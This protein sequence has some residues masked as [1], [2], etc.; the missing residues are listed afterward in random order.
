MTNK[1]KESG[2]QDPKNEH[3]TNTPPK[4]PGTEEPNNSKETGHGN[5]G[6]TKKG[7]GNEEGGTS[8][9]ENA[10][11]PVKP[12]EM[13]AERIDERPRLRMGKEPTTTI[14]TAPVPPITEDVR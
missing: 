4:G 6:Q 8:T 12:V 9:E 3:E 1:T 5:G 2:G 14:A 10:K 7:D 11:K 13:S